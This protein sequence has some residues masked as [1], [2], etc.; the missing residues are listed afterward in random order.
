MQ[1]LELSGRRGP[2]NPRSRILLNLIALCA[3]TRP[4]RDT[5]MIADISQNPPFGDHLVHGESPVLTTTSQLWV[6]RAGEALRA[7]HCAALMGINLTDVLAYERM[8]DAWMCGRLGMA[9]HVGNFGVVL[10]AALV[11]CVRQAVG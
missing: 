7:K 5:L 8:T 9:V 6:L 2:G 4:L 11:P 3:K 1:I 10:L